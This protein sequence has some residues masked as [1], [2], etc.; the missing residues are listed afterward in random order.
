MLGF[1]LMPS[2]GYAC[3]KSSEKTSCK[4]ET[5][6]KKD[7]AH[8]CQENCCEKGHDSKKDPHGCS[9]KCNHSSCTTSILQF[10]LITANEFDFNN[11]LFNFSPEK[12]ISYYKT[13]SLCDGFASIWLIPKI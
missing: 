1:F 9:G 6:S 8:T 5:S 13:A 12:S 3:E 2:S 10:S 4:K 11:N 7:S